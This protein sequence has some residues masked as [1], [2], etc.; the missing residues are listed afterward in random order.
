MESV[1]AKLAEV[2]AEVEEFDEA[3]ARARS[4]HESAG[5]EEEDEDCL[6]GEEFA[7]L[8]RTSHCEAEQHDDDVIESRSGSLC[9][10][11]CLAGF[12]Q[13]VAEEEH[14]EERHAGWHD[15]CSDEQSDD[16]EENA[17]SLRHLS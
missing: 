17:F 1:S 5:T 13:Q 7:C 6:Y 14:T 16:G 11:R 3:D 12:F 4:H 9:Q 8:C 15:E 2:G 10:T